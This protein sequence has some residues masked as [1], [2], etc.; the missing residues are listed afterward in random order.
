M[1]RVRSTAWYVGDAAIG[2]SDG[3]GGGFEERTACVQLSDVVSHSKVGD[4]TD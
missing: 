2:G 3:E 1:A 4:V